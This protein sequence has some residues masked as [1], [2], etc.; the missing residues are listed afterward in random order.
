MS[1]V[2]F[3]E[4]KMEKAAEKAAAAI[5]EAANVRGIDMPSFPTPFREAWSMADDGECLSRAE[6]LATMLLTYLAVKPGTPYRTIPLS[7][8]RTAGISNLSLQTLD[9]AAHDPVVSSHL[10]AIFEL[11][12][13]S[14]RTLNISS[15]YGRGVRSLDAYLPSL[16]H[17]SIANG[18][19]VQDSDLE[20][21]LSRC[22]GL[23]SFIFEACKHYSIIL[24]VSKVVHRHGSSSMKS[25]FRRLPV[26]SYLAEF[27]ATY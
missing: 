6:E 3:E 18:Q 22:N 12:S 15:C 11:S 25:E 2:A 10:G 16:R 17:I 4:M 8:L 13:H 20:F 24:S 5:E 14:I 9:I 26:R 27:L 7:S 21:L 1:V 23:E 19:E